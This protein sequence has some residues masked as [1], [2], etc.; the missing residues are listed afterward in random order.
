MSAYAMLA[1]AVAKVHVFMCGECEMHVNQIM[2]MK[3]TVQVWMMMQFEAPEHEES[4]AVE[5]SMRCD[6]V[7]R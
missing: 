3:N 6:D 7:R 4:A 1:G 2:R 5:Y